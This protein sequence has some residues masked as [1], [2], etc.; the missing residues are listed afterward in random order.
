MRGVYRSSL[1]RDADW[2]TSL[3]LGCLPVWKLRYYTIIQEP[4]IQERGNRAKW[5]GAH[6]QQQQQ[7]AKIKAPPPPLH[8]DDG[9]PDVAGPFANRGA[10]CGEPDQRPTVPHSIARVI[11]PGVCA[12]SREAHHYTHMPSPAEIIDKPERT[13][14]ILMVV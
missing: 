4:A 6:Q 11:Y 10:R 8:D 2:L 12:S 7:R 9:V 3:L 1:G 5:V 14:R 13:A